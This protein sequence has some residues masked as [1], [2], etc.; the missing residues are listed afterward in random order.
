[1]NVI[2]VFEVKHFKSKYAEFV[3]DNGS[4]ISEKIGNYYHL[5]QLCMEEFDEEPVLPIYFKLNDDG[6]FE[7]IKHKGLWLKPK[8]NW[9]K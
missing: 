3:L 4:C 8:R 2:K 1:M 7:S 5:I 6:Q 9:G